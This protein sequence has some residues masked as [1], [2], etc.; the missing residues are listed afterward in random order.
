[1][2]QQSKLTT[3]IEGPVL[4]YDPKNN[5]KK[6]EPKCSLLKNLR[7]KK[8]VSRTRLSKLTNLSTYQVEGLEGPSAQNLMERLL[9]CTK[10]LGYKTD[11]ILRMMER[12][13]EASF[14]KGTIG[15]SLF[16]KVFQEGAKLNMYLDQ[17]GY[18]IPDP[19]PSP[20]KGTR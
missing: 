13:N 9:I 6:P 11:D 3:D 18:S 17:D 7:E 12:G 14:L 15:K 20:L 19:V 4:E 2:T 8:K 10:A 16:E 1:M 5:G